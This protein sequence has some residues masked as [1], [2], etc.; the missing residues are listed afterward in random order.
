MTCE[1][2]EPMIKPKSKARWIITG[3]LLLAA[4]FFTLSVFANK[5]INR[6]STLEK[7]QTKLSQ[8]VKGFANAALLLPEPP[9]EPWHH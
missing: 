1:I 5:V 2:S 8:A 7:I 3:V 9:K 4:L 6:K